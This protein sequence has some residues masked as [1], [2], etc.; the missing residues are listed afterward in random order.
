MNRNRMLIGVVIAL[1]IALVASRYVYRQIQNAR[2]TVKP[3]ATSAVVVAA[4]PLQ[5]GTPLQSKNLRVVDWPAGTQPQ[6]TFSNVN[7][8][9]GR[10]LITSVVANEPILEQ[11]LAPKEAGAGLPAAIPEGMRAVSVRV[12]DVVDVAGFVQP[13]TMVDVLVTGTPPTAGPHATLTRTFL[14]DVR[15]LAAGQQVEQDKNGKPHTVN[16][17]TLLV[18]PE[19][20]DTLTLAST[21]GT[22]HLSLRNTIDT[23]VSDPPPAYLAGL[24][25]G[26]GVVA[27]PVRHR[28][29]DPRPRPPA[30][31]GP[32]VVEIYQG[33]KRETASFPSK[34][35]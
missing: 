3:M 34:S 20:A 8:C 30:P 18:T 5:I 25:L 12:D 16:V 24:Y 15:V 2:V 19:Q 13:G 1:I 14:E 4:A 27:F 23:K 9:L 29:V 6:G 21:E 10:A 31:A 26:G 35:K 28:K 32:Y 22:I 17:V 33:D 7:Q 11:Q